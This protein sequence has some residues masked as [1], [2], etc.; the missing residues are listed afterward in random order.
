MSSPM[1]E[2][3]EH[4]LIPCNKDGDGP[5]PYEEAVKWVCWCEE[6]DCKELS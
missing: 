1:F 3:P 5:V 2:L 4:M 6:K